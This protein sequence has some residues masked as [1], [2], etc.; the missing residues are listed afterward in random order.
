MPKR[1]EARTQVPLLEH[2][3]D[4]V[5][6]AR[7]RR[8]HVIE[9]TTRLVVHDEER[10]VS[11]S[12]ALHQ[13][14]DHACHEA[15]PE[16]HIR[17]RVLVRGVGT[18]VRRLQPNVRRQRVGLCVRKKAVNILEMVALDVV[19]VGKYFLFE[20]HALGV[21]HP[22]DALLRQLLKERLLLRDPFFGRRVADVT[23]GRPRVKEHAVRPSGAE[24]RSE[25]AIADRERA[26]QG[27]IVTEVVRVV[28][29]ERARS[30]G[31]AGRDEAVHLAVAKL[32]VGRVPIVPRVPSAE[33]RLVER[34]D[35][36]VALRVV[37]LVAGRCHVGIG[38]AEL[39]QLLKIV[40]ERAIFL[41]HD[42]EVID[43]DAL[44][45]GIG[46]AQGS[47]GHVTLLELASLS[48]LERGAHRPRRHAERPEGVERVLRS[49]RTLRATR[50]RWAVHAYCGRCA[51]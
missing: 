6:R 51:R 18:A 36:A 34:F 49:S 17:G 12:R 7:L 11:P 16:L 25:V 46:G 29:A 50:D 42:H 28:V 26:R 5:R 23:E 35:V 37:V 41:H 43:R 38:L 4:V 44:A 31:I 27:V 48:A 3:L 30:L 10:G 1:F 14:V 20:G 24:H 47:L 13:R 39:G 8:R 9:K 19:E 2:R 33:R 45:N 15:L 22:L 21:H 32:Y 40:I